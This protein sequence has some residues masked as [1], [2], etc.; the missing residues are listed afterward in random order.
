MGWLKRFLK[1]KS[2]W[3]VFPKE[4]ELEGVFS[5]GLDYVERIEGLTTNPFWQDVL[6]ALRKLWK[7]NIVYDKKV[8][9][10]A[11]LWYNP[12]FRLEI[13]REW[14]EK[15]IMVISDLIDYLTVPLTMEKLQEKFD[16]KINFLENGKISAALRKHFE[17]KD[18]P[19]HREPLLRNSFLNT[20]LSLDIKGVSNLYRALQHQGNHI[21]GEVSGK[22]EDKLRIH[23]SPTE[24]SRSFAFHHR[25]YKDCYL[26]YTQFRTLHRRFYTNDKL[27]KMGKKQSNLCTFC[28]TS[29]DNV[30]HMLLYCPIIIE[31]W[32]KVN[33]WL[34]EI[35]FINFRFTDYKKIL[36]DIDNGII[37]TTIIL[38]TKKVIYNCFKKDSIPTIQYI[39]NET[40][41][42]LLSGKI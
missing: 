33:K 7:S 37:I 18:I 29:L 25:T 34:I 17:W 10:E 42:I 8:I 4:L 11:P 23:I 32:D 15:V 40:K 39:Q 14:K 36:G 3:T 26:K 22:W 27:F 9:T 31:L 2:K 41:K 24:I 19:D 38:L 13:K 5:L 28:K 12:N 16:I 1:S 6:N 35:G 21:L 20:I 30:E